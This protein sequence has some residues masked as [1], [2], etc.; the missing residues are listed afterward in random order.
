MGEIK[1]SQLQCVFVRALERDEELSCHFWGHQITVGS[2]GSSFHSSSIMGS[3][4]LH[5]PSV[6]NDSSLAET[7][8]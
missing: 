5:S 7:V 6:T 8:I 4:I 2:T 1:M 3:K